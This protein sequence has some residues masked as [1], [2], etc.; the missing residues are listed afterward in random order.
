[1]TLAIVCEIH[2]RRECGTRGAYT[3]SSAY[4][5]RQKSHGLRSGDQDRTKEWVLLVLSMSFE[6]GM[7]TLL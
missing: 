6:R 2:Y 7:A 4:P 5:H 3:W 1:M